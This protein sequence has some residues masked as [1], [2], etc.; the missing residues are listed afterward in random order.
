MNIL[1]LLLQTT[2]T[3]DAFYIVMGAMIAF[4]LTVAALITAVSV[5][6]L[7]TIKPIKTYFSDN[8]FTPI[9]TLTADMKDLKE[10][11]GGLESKYAERDLIEIVRCFPQLLERVARLEFRTTMSDKNSRTPIFIMSEN[12]TCV[13]V[14][15]AL[16]ELIRCD[17]S[18]I[19]NRD[20][21]NVIAPQS[22]SAVVAAWREAYDTFTPFNNEQFLL[23]EGELTKVRV[24]ADPFIYDGKLKAFVGTVTILQ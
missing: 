10:R 18:Q 6:Y 4:V 13:Y 20:W 8:L 22:R 24:T 14:N 19:V 17:S 3:S 23:V 9:T 21:V 5:I 2:T 16:C 12:T 11:V 7:K 15:Q 1:F